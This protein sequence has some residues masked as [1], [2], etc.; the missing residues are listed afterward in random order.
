ML[1]FSYGGITFGDLIEDDYLN[2]SHALVW[3]NNKGEDH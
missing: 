1:D 2:R 3:F